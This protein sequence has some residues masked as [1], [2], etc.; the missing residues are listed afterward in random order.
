[1]F[2]YRVERT[3]GLWAVLIVAGAGV[4]VQAGQNRSND[5][6]TKF[7]LHQ[8]GTVL[9]LEGESEVHDK[10][11]EVRRLS[12]EVSNAVMLQRSTMSE[13][14]YQDS[15]KE[16]NAEINQ[17]RSELN[18]TNQA[19]GRLP[20]YRG[21][22]TNNVVVE[23][24]FELNLYKRQLQWEMNQ[25]TTLLQRLRGQPFDPKARLQRDYAVRDKSEALHQAGQDLRKAVDAVK[26]KYDQIDKDPAF[27]KALGPLEKKAGMKLKLGPS[28]HFQLDV[29]LL[30]KLESQESA[31]D[32]APKGTPKAQHPAKGRRSSKSTGTADSGS[33]S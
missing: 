33:S 2:P 8:A 32:S 7:G 27:K 26:E 28:R 6:L 30:E 10:T 25:R 29:K 21:R 9:V 11:E 16:L 13:K 22:F 23:Q 1:M 4:G 5:P 3:L 24:N 17:Y 14:Q 18:A 19:I 31:G 12:R 20:R 15:I